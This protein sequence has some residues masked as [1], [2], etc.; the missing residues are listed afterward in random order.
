MSNYTAAVEFFSSLCQAQLNQP[1]SRLDAANDGLG[2][3]LVLRAEPC[4]FCAALLLSLT[5]WL[6]TC[7]LQAVMYAVSAAVSAFFFASW[8]RL[9][10]DSKSRVWRRYG[11]FS[12]L[13]FV[14]S[15]GGLVTM[16]ADIQFRYNF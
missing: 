13:A 10:D 2:A 7:C 5:C 12:A 8:K 14:G 11:W 1:P 15:V 4:S 16:A 6:L 3:T 9:D